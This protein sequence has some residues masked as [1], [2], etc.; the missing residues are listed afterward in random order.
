MCPA[1]KTTLYIYPGLAAATV[2]LHGHTVWYAYVT[3]TFFT[4]AASA[5]HEDI[6]L[7]YNKITLSFEIQDKN[8]V[9]R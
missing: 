2:K 9:S 7:E 1:P 3:F 8:C 4:I 6:A 5:Y